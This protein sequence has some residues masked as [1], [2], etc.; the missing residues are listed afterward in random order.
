MLV[1]SIDQYKEVFLLVRREFELVVQ[2]RRI[3]LWNLVE[4]TPYFRA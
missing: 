2:V 4:V 1:D 3:Y